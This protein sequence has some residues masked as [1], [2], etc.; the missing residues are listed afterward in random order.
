MVILIVVVCCCLKR[1]QRWKPQEPRSLPSIRYLFPQFF[2]VRS[3][4]SSCDG[5][6][7]PVL[8]H[9]G[10]KIK[11]DYTVKVYAQRSAGGTPKL[12]DSMITDHSYLTIDDRKVTPELSNCSLSSILFTTDTLLKDRDVSS[13]AFSSEHKRI[14]SSRDQSFLHT[15]HKK[16]HSRFERSSTRLELCEAPKAVTL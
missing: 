11:Q 8:T 16:K 5:N 6:K 15:P 12:Y 13:I 4:E 3:L 10:Y 14:L 7:S 1:I 9:E 2:K